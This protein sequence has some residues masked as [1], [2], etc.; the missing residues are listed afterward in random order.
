MCGLDSGSGVE[1]E[2]GNCRSAVVAI[3]NLLSIG[4]S[5]KL[6][7][8]A[9]SSKTRGLRTLLGARVSAYLHH[10]TLLADEILW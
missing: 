8:H 1:A 4:K 3:N 2:T 7:K 10:V 6:V 9:E 5:A